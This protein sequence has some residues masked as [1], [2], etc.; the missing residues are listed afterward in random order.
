MFIFLHDNL[1]TNEVDN[2]D[3]NCKVIWPEAQTQGK[4]I[5]VGAFYRPSSTKESSLMD[6]ACYIQG[7]KNK[8][9][10]HI[11]LGGDFNLP[12]I[13]YKKSIKAGSNQHIQN[14]Q[15][16][17]MAQE[18]GLEQMQLNPSRQSNIL[19]LYFTTYPSL[20]KSSYTVSGISDNYIVVVDC[21]EKPRHNKPK[22]GKIYIYNK[23]NCTNI[24]SNVRALSMLHYVHYM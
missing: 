11:V 23:A 24:K 13:N 9:N 10:K 21:D 8:Q 12:H 22:H 19:D 14:Q 17:D 1:T 4:P 6:L 3:S 16:L 18:L 5:T 20:V 2:H 15:L 7:I